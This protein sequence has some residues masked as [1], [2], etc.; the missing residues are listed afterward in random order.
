MVITSF[1]VPMSLRRTNNLT[2]E[3]I[4]V[5]QCDRT[6]FVLPLSIHI[7]KELLSSSLNV[8]CVKNSRLNLAQPLD[9]FLTESSVG[10]HYKKISTYV[11]AQ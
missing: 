11:T 1:D 7:G 4:R 8:L 9:G 10:L 5:R 6:S 2:P 3:N